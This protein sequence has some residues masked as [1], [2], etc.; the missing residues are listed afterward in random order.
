[1][2]FTETKLSF[3]FLYLAYHYSLDVF[4]LM[5]QVTKCGT[6]DMPTTP[7]FQVRERWRQA[8]VYRA[9]QHKPI[10]CYAIVMTD[11]RSYDSAFKGSSIGFNVTIGYN[12]IAY[13]RRESR[14]KLI[15]WYIQRGL[16]YALYM[17]LRFRQQQ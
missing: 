14:C 1:M 8:E 11:L 2:T 5:A 6:A 9:V 15:Q 16:L 17:L 3:S 10:A 4:R 12:I 13:I 7:L